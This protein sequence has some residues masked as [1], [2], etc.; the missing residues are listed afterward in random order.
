[1]TNDD[2]DGHAAAEDLWIT[3]E[4]LRAWLDG[5][6]RLPPQ[7]ALLLRVLK[8]SEEVGE[9]A[10]AVIGAVGQNPRK[11]VS[12]TWQDVESEL[13]DV[14][15]TA[16]VALGTLNPDARTALTTHVARVAD[17]SLGAG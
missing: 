11:G 9:V 5:N 8:L 7:E 16:L 6:N 1:M 10:E 13:C 2:A 12:H 17:R 14:I 15:V 3:V 4:R